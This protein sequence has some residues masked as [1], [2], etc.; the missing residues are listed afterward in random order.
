MILKSLIIFIFE[1]L[2]IINNLMKIIFQTK[3]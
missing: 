3:M 1:K 2:K